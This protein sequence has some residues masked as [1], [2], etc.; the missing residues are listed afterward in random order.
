MLPPQADIE[1]KKILK[2]VSSANKKLGELKGLISSIPNSLIIIN[3]LSLREAKDSSEIENIVTTND[4]LFK[5][6][7]DIPVE[8][9]NTKEVKNYNLA[10][11]EGYRLVKEKEM[12]TTNMIAEIQGILE[13]NKIGIRTQM[14]TVLKNSKGEIIYTPPQNHKEILDLMSNLEEYINVDNDDIDFLIKLAVIHYQFESIHPFYD[15][16]GRTGR[17]INILYLILKDLLD[18]PILYLSSYIIKNKSEYYR[19]LQDVRDKNDWESWILYMLNGIEEISEETIKII[20]RISNSM[21]EV[22]TKILEDNKK[23]YSKDLLEVLFK[24]PYT[25]LE[26]LTN[27]LSISRQTASKYLNILTEIGILDKIKIQNTNYYINI[28]LLKILSN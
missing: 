15:G 3:T 9:N 13:K 24:H 18:I 4:E 6:D 19:L 27:E 20:K 10:L 23:I 11:K 5:A 14:G 21:K 8:N 1:T 16:N 25:K 26:F 22:K 7:I 12:L 2:K 28:K 17:I